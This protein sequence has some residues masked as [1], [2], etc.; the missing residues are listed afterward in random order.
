RGG[1]GGRLLTDERDGLALEPVAVHEEHS[2]DY[3]QRHRR[4]EVERGGAPAVDELPQAEAREEVGGAHHAS[5]PSTVSRCAQ[6]WKNASSM[7]RP[8]R[9]PSGTA[10]ASLARGPCALIWPS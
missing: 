4:G 7:P 1:D 8:L 3:Q 5:A 2:D 10:A 9:S 6:K